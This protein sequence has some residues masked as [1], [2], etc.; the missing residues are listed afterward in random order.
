VGSADT[1]HLLDTRVPN[2]GIQ[3]SS[4]SIGVGHKR[5]RVSSSGSWGPMHGLRGMLQDQYAR[6]TAAA[7]ADADQV[8]LQLLLTRNRHAL[9]RVEA[10]CLPPAYRPDS[11]RP[12]QPVVLAVAGPMQG[13]QELQRTCAAAGIDPM[14]AEQAL[15]R[16][17]AAAAVSHGKSFD[18][19]LEGVLT[20]RQHWIDTSWR[21]RDD[22]TFIF[23]V[24]LRH[25]WGH[26]SC[27]LSGVGI[28]LSDSD[29][30]AR[31]GAGVM[32]LE[33]RGHIPPRHSRVLNVYMQPIGSN[34]TRCLWSVMCFASFVCHVCS[35]QP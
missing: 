22:I 23:I 30:A 25:E 1:V 18:S 33:G 17:A 16:A 21:I 11:N 2:G 10:N 4:S 28:W 31:V 14:L 27:P 35:E 6:A 32:P 7:V 12:V 9:W 34:C 15:R 29:Y 24:P 19:A 8:H 13:M 3:R 26:G 20:L 5:S